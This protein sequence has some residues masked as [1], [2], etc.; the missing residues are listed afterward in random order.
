MTKGLAFS[1]V[2]A[3]FPYFG[4]TAK[5]ETDARR[6]ELLRTYARSWRQFVQ[7]PPLF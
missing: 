4:E 5:A 7:I 3:A 1:L 2:A 6:A